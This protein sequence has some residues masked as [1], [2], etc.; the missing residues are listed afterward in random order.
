MLLL[1]GLLDLISMQLASESTSS[2]KTRGL[3]VLVRQPSWVLEDVE[4][5]DG[6]LGSELSRILLTFVCHET[7]R[8]HPDRTV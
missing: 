3:S 8:S 6:L 7:G 2:G 4:D 5:G 1:I